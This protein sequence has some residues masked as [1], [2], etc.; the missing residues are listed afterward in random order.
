MQHFKHILFTIRNRREK[1]KL[2][3]EKGILFFKLKISIKKTVH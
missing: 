1:E 3:K 2:R